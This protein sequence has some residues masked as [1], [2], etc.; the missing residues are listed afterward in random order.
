MS[1]LILFHK[2]YGVLSQF[3]DPEGRKTLADYIDKKG[4]YAAGRLDYDSEG[5]MVLTSD[6]ELQHR[7][8]HPDF[9]LPKH[10]WVQLEGEITDTALNQLI[11]GVEL[12]DGI[13]KRAQ[14]KRIPAPAI[15]PRNP[16][17][18]E[19]KSVPTCWIELVISEGKNRQVRRMTAA[20][21]FPTLRLVRAA[22]GH[23][24]LGDLAPGSYLEDSVHLPA[25]SPRVK[26]KQNYKK[27]PAAR[28][29]HSGT[30]KK[31]SSRRATNNK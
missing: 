25:A 17:I 30:A 28:S 21:G 3:T 13:T 9:K 18:R 12:K 7:L 19:R 2:P 31:T 15:G 8:A 4:F 10:Y 22:I 23:W 1:D 6:G 29:R 26:K 16:P 24:K 27:G 5:L 20:V 14:A 11:Q